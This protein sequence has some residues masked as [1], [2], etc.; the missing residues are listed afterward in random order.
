[1][2]VGGESRAML[3]EHCETEDIGGLNMDYSG[4]GGDKF[5]VYLATPAKFKKGWLP[6]WIDEETLI[7][8][9]NGI[10]LKLLTA[11]IGKCVPIGGFD[12]KRKKPKPMLRAVPAGSVY[13]FKILDG[14]NLGEAMSCFHYSNISDFDAKQGFGLAFAGRAP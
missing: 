4:M 12:M 8:K 14:C 2:K 11:A 7:G 9:F 1:M 10:S 13:Y 6:D 5:K 3:Y